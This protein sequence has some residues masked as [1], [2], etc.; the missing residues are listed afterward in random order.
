MGDTV[1]HAGTASSSNELPNE[2]NE[3]DHEQE[4]NQ[5]SR[6]VEDYKAK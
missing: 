5:A 2:G 3:S 6:D 4:M 1:L